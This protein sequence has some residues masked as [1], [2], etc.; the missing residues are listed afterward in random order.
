MKK[1]YI[2]SFD[3]KPNRSYRN[4]HEAIKAFGTWAR[5]TESTYAVVTESSAKTIRDYLVQFI[6][7]EERIFVIRSGG[8]AAWHQ[9]ISD[10]DWLKKFLP[11]T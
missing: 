9:A 2:I 3:L 11:L 8:K 6:N 7:P 10:T 1:C 4:F 5:V